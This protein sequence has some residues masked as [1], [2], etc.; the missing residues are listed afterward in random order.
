MRNLK[1]LPI[2]TFAISVI[3]GT[4]TTGSAFVFDLE[5]SGVNPASD[6]YG[7]ITLTL[8]ATGQIEVDVTMTGIYRLGSGFGFNYTTSGPITI[9]D[10]VATSVGSH[11]SS[12]AQAVGPLHLDGFGDFEAGL[13]AN[14]NEHDYLS[15]SFNVSRVDGFTSIDQILE[16]SGNY[17]ALFV[18]HVYPNVSNGSTGFIGASGATS[19][20]EPATLILIGVGLLGLAGFRRKY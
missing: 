5:N 1:I 2:L 13:T 9:S 14:S 6:N 17:N 15:L 7:T 18:T 20:P 16:P 3:L 4:A 19:V 12:W 8:D 10:I 11:V